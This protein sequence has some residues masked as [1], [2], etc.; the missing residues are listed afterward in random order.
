MSTAPLFSN[1]IRCRVIAV[2]LRI[3]WQYLVRPTR[4]IRRLN[5]HLTLRRLF[6]VF[7]Y[8][9]N[10]AVVIHAVSLRW[11]EV[12]H[13]VRT[14]STDCC[15]ECTALLH[16]SWALQNVLTRVLEAVPSMVTTRWLLPTHALQILTECPVSICIRF[17]APA[18]SPWLNKDI[19]TPAMLEPRTYN[20]LLLIL[21]SLSQPLRLKLPLN[22]L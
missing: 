21:T 7:M 11:F 1:F 5:F 12:R 2:K 16:P 9:K 22:G 8:S 15:I 14:M 13:D 18:D 19:G 3:F 10:V 6:Y 4:G 17:V 20:V